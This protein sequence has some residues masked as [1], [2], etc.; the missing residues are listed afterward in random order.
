MKINRRV[1]GILILTLA[2]LMVSFFSACSDRDSKNYAPDEGSSVID[3]GNLIMPSG[4]GR[5]II[6]NVNAVI[7]TD[8]FNQTL[9]KIDD[10]LNQINSD[11]EKKSY[12][13]KSEIESDNPYAEI[14]LRIK[15]EKLPIFLDMFSDFGTVINRQVS[16]EDIT[17]KYADTAAELAAYQA[18]LVILQGLLEETTNPDTAFKYTTRITEINKKINYYQSLLNSYDS[19]VDFSTVT[20]RIYAKGAVPPAEKY[21]T[22]IEKVFFGSLDFL[23]EIFKFLFLALVAIWPYALIALGLFFLIKYIRRYLKKKYPHKFKSKLNQFENPD[24][25]NSY[26]NKE[27]D[28][29]KTIY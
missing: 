16:S 28:N 22:K 17:E 12:I 19:V 6:Y 1:L 2:L 10:S 25:N 14:T 15:T 21:T 9:E 13:S 8:K 4:E 24:Q 26:Q 23:A 5:K 11:E 7:E 18:E 27:Q 29:D 3:G 20:L